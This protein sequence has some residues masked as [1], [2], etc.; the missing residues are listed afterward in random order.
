MVQKKTVDEKIDT[1]EN[2]SLAGNA[3]EVVQRY[4]SANKEHFVAYSGSDNEAGKILKKGLKSI[5]ESKINENYR[6]Q[7]IKQ[8]AGFSAEVKSVAR[9][10]AEYILNR[11]KTR[12]VRTD[13]IGRLNDPLF[14][15]VTVD[16][17][18][19]IVGGPGIQIKFV[20]KSPGDALSKLASKKF[21][22][23][24]DADAEIEVQSDFYDG[25]KKE[26]RE[27]I[28]KLQ[29]EA[30]VLKTQGKDEVLQKKLKEIEKYKKIKKSLRKSPVSNKGAV[31]ARL[32]P[33]ISTAKDIVKISHRA[34]IDQAKSGA[35]IA[36]GISLVRNIVAVV[37]D[38]KTSQEAA[39]AVA[40]DT[41][42]GAVVSYATAFSGSVIKGALQNAKSTTLKTVSKTN[43]PATLVVT[44]LETG[45]TLNKYFSG[46]ID[47]VECLE[48]LGEKGTGMLSSAIF[49]TVGQ[50]AIP[51][52][53]LGGLIGSML[54]YALSS[55]CYTQLMGV[56]KEA[57]LAREERLIIEAE[58]KESIKLIREYRA[59]M[60]QILSTYIVDYTETF[61]HGF[62]KIKK[63]LNLDDIDGFIAGTNKITKKLG[64]KPQFETFNEFD[65]LM[66]QEKSFKL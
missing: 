60:E 25:I 47:G 5:S 1:L 24:L 48:E 28:E 46:D 2:V 64:G 35:V 58:C 42:T 36:G 13:D 41:G 40:K 12:V 33:K 15:T 62:G 17:S 45:K 26:A 6:E 56:L 44:V 31:E 32:H 43:L 7:N 51:I 54:G 49:A 16:P 50:I 55:A 59:E 63:A 39:I 19:T 34:G 11:S 65:A 4:G 57:K 9:K 27:K 66:R 52:P 38:E 61:H 29:K 22:K 20:G 37:K 18:G 30:T 10:N 23:Y 21:E 8:Q 53:V 14:D 3:A